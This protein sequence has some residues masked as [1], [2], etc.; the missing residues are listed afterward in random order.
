VERTGTPGPGGRAV[1]VR[2]ATWLVL[3]V[4]GV[5]LAL[6]G[7]F[8]APSVPHVLAVPVPVGPLVAL[9]GNLAVGLFGA[10]GTGSRV[11]AAVP[12]VAWFITIQFMAS[13]RPEGDLVLTSTAT[14]VAVLYLGAIA[15]AV[16]I[17]LGP[18]R[19][20]WIRR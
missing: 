11:G 12:G 3:V 9:V 13:S 14:G 17:L 20:P 1:L 4:L 6:I 15:A 18:H 8:L 10:R 19:L 16:P 2:V 5:E 7:A